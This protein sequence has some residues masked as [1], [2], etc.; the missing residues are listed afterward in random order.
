MK[1]KTYVYT[2]V[3]VR[4]TAR[5]LVSAEYIVEDISM[6]IFNPLRPITYIPAG[7]FSLR[8]GAL[9]WGDSVHLPNCRPRAGAQGNPPKAKWHYARSWSAVNIKSTHCRI[10]LRHTRTISTK[11]S[12]SVDQRLRKSGCSL[13]TKNGGLLAWVDS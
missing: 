3:Q 13:T 12:R 4:P 6:K 5:P 2:D 1:Q 9:A 7:D 11:C 10:Y 8:P